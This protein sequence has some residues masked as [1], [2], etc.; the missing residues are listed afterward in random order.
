MTHNARMEPP[1]VS[2]ARSGD[3]AVASQVVGGGP[4]DILFLRGI[5]EDRGLQ[6]LKVIPD[7]WHLHAVTGSR[8][9]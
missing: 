4:T 9:A 2:H 5:T 6:S 3:V 7:P 8:E 1:D